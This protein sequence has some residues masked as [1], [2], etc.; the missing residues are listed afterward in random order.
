MGVKAAKKN[1]IPLIIQHCTDLYEFVDHYPAVLPGVLALA[2]VVFPLSVKL[3]GQ[4]L[5]EVA[6]LYRPR[7]GVTK[8]NKDIIERVITILYSKADAVIALSRK[9]R[10][11][12]ESWQTEDYTYD[13]TF[14]AKRRECSS[15]SQTRNESQNFANNGILMKKMKCLDLWDV[16]VRKRICQF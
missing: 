6:K 12:L 9:S 11:Q 3:N 10:D 7:N 1:N 2:G 14:N 16:W 13:V 15:A 8:W 4:D 5:L